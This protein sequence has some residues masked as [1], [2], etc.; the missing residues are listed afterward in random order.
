MRKIILINGL[1]AAIIIAG[2]S[3]VMLWTAGNDAAHSQAEWLGYLIM[4][5]GLS[6]IFV[7][8]KQVRDQQG[9][10][11][12][13]FK[14]LQVGLLVTLIAAF[15]YVA[16]WEVYYQ[17]AGQDFIAAYQD[18]QLGQMA[19]SGA[20]QA[21]LDEARTNMAQFAEWYS[22]WYI[23]ALITLL[24]ILPVGVLITLVA[25]GLLR[26]RQTG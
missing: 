1:I 5:A 16:S 26:S 12:G 22:Q 14:G 19:E 13:F 25:A 15:F 23:R 9:G 10:V 20:S 11:I 17:S 24:E 3:S 18:S 8:I 7:A 6:I 4:V 21:E 2:V